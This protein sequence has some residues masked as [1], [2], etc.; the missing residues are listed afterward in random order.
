[1]EEVIELTELVAL[2][3]TFLSSLLGYLFHNSE[4]ASEKVRCPEGWVEFITALASSSLVY[5]L[6]HHDHE[7]HRVV[8]R[9]TNGF[10]AFDTRTLHYLKENCPIIL[11]LLQKVKEFPQKATIFSFQ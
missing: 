3:A 1:M 10:S 6:L 8:R 7:L 2:K 11:N 9:I 4:T 5:A